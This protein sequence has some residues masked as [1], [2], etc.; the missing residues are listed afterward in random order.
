MDH[1][2]SLINSSINCRRG[3]LLLTDICRGRYFNEYQMRCQHRGTTKMDT[4]RETGS[5][6]EN[7]DREINIYFLYNRYYPESYK[8]Y[9]ELIFYSAT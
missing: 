8:I 4:K 1:L 7:N 3:V 5:Q 9:N 2:N 6:Y